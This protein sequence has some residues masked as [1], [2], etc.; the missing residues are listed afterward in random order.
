MVMVVVNTPFTTF[1]C[2]NNNSL[3]EACGP[4]H[5][6]NHR[7]KEHKKWLAIAHFRINV[8]TRLALMGAKH[9]NRAA[10]VTSTPI[11][12]H[13]CGS[14]RE[15]KAFQRILSSMKNG[16]SFIKFGRDVGTLADQ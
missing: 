2:N 16:M 10:T 11:L 13:G 15:M 9:F 6:H 3:L 12:I 4:Y 1:F 7:T 14:E 8:C 5:K